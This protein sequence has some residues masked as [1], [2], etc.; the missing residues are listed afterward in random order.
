MWY[1]IWLKN[2]ENMPQ[3]TYQLAA[4]PNG[5]PFIYC[6][7]VSEDRAIWIVWTNRAEPIAPDYLNNMWDKDGEIRLEPFS[8][9]PLQLTQDQRN[10]FDEHVATAPRW[11]FD[12]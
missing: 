3:S 6:G 11:P 8:D 4:S 10:E 2:P 7:S 9:Y 5:T 12:D 1:K